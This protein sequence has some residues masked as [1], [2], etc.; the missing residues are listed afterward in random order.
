MLF[1]NRYRC[2][3]RAGPVIRRRVGV[4][5][6]RLGIRAWAHAVRRYPRAVSP[7]PVC[8]RSRAPSAR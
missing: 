3:G 7:G 4:V 2:V 8:P 5:R 1:C 6:T